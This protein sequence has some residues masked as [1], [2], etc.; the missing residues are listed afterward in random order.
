[1]KKLNGIFNIKGKLLIN[2]HIAKQK[3]KL[4]IRRI[5][6]G[7]HLSLCAIR[8]LTMNIQVKVTYQDGSYYIADG[9]HNLAKEDRRLYEE[10][11]SVF[12]ETGTTVIHTNCRTMEL[13]IN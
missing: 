2:V 8:R 10:L 3:I 9:T 11:K 12:V 7:T 13:I 6:T 1:M 5:E 4:L